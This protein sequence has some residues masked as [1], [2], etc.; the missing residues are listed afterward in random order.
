MEQ[1]TSFEEH[2]RNSFEITSRGKH[3]LGMEFVVNQGE[4]SVRQS[5]YIRDILER[6]SM[7]ECKAVSTPMESGSY[8]KV[9]TTKKI[10]RANHFLIGRGAL[11]YLSVCT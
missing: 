11:M 7:S 9:D 3:C 2:L 10:Q 6:Y 8:S 5:A 4:I 1:I